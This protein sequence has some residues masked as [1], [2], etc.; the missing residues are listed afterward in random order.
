MTICVQMI[1]E[2]QSI[3]ICVFSFVGSFILDSTSNDMSHSTSPTGFASDSLGENPRHSYNE[4]YM[5]SQNFNFDLPSNTMGESQ[6]AFSFLPVN[7]DYPSDTYS[8]QNNF[9]PPLPYKNQS[10]LNDRSRRYGHRFETPILYQLQMDSDLRHDLGLDFARQ[11]SA[12][13]LSGEN[14]IETSIFS[15][16]HFD[17]H[18][19]HP[20]Y[21]YSTPLI[22]SSEHLS[23]PPSMKPSD[24][25]PLQSAT[26]P[27][28][29]HMKLESDSQYHHEIPSLSL[30]LPSRNTNYTNKQKNGM[31][32]GIP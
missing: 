12:P 9:L 20:G 25:T 24:E 15:T 19:L 18:L 4:N 27:S 26:S 30:S 23:S 14:D 11:V 17:P 28:S 22:Y 10:Q 31:I 6:N 3:V 29:S 5:S 2:S 1:L 13:N 8:P 16:N 7:H 32:S 21:R